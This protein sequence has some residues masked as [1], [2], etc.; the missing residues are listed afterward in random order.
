MITTPN[1]VAVADDIV[2][3]QLQVDIWPEYDRPA[4]LVIYRIGLTA[5]TTLPATL[6]LN[7]PKDA[8]RPSRLA[9]QDVDGMFYNIDFTTQ[10]AAEWVSITFT[11]PSH[12]IQLEYYDPNITFTQYQRAYQ[13]TW[14]NDL[15]VNALTVRVQQP[16]NAT[17]IL[18]EPD[19]GSGRIGQDGLEYFIFLAGQIHANEEYT[20]K[21][22]YDKPDFMLSSGLL[23]VSPV[24]P[25]TLRTKGR[26]TATLAVPW[27]LALLGIVLIVT[28]GLWYWQ[29]GK[30]APAYELHTPPIEPTSR[31]LKQ[32]QQL[33][34]QT[35]F[36]CSK[37]GKRIQKEDKFCKE[38]GQKN[39]SE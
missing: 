12:E 21:L 23:P 24:K 32:A 6:T 36:Y 4:V 33:I 27:A 11:T 9:V 13:F 2:I 30:R 18:I 35:F 10:D 19:M 28:G 16:V 5:D 38:C 14:Q 37:C 1:A 17:K 26:T 15:P 25:I 31:S 8:D 34:S 7:I 22:T 29:I 3:E 39:I 20:V